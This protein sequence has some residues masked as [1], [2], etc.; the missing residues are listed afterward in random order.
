MIMRNLEIE[1]NRIIEFAKKDDNIRALVLQGS[2]VNDSVIN[3]DFSDLDPLFYVKDV[4]KFTENEEWK[5]YFGNP[6]SGFADE[7]EIH[8]GLKWYTRLTIYDDSFKIDFGFQSVKLAKYANEMP[9]YRIY[10]DKDGILPKPEVSDDRKFHVTKP[11]EE[12]FLDRMNA[13]FYDSSYVV[14]AL[15][16]NEIFFAKFMA[17]ELNMKIKK[18]LDWYIGIK[19]DFKV[20]PGLIGRYYRRYLDEEVWQMLL[21]TYSD[22]NIA[23]S[24]NALLASYDLVR[25]LGKF[26][27]KELEFD[28]P[29]KHNQDMLAY[30][31]KIIDKYL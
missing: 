17:N 24:A 27:S 23:N 22:G 19:H 21:K 11:T 18:L 25:Y 3:D 26:I 28:Y 4:K 12:E 9:L 16:R 31:K 14:K 5:N 1:L 2:Y 15:A 13:F 10:L 29:E 30:C 7:G 6:I 8:D 20:N